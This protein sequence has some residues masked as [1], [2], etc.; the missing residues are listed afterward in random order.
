MYIENMFDGAHGHFLKRIGQFLD[1]S[2]LF[3]SPGLT[4]GDHDLLPTFTP[5]HSAMNDYQF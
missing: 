2:A 4:L 3:Q 1:I 5:R